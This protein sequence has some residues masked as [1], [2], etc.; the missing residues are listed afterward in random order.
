MIN[1]DFPVAGIVDVGHI[2]VEAR[3]LLHFIAERLFV[4]KHADSRGIPKAP[5]LDVYKR[6]G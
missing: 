5:G 4:E 1:A 2:L 6:Q 3:R